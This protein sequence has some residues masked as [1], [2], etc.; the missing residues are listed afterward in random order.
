MGRDAKRRV[1]IHLQL[2]RLLSPYTNLRLLILIR[3]P[4][5]CLCKAIKERRALTFPF[6]HFMNK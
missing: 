2:S 5:C 1:I 6:M 4:F 3:F